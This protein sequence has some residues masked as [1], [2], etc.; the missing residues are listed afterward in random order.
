MDLVYLDGMGDPASARR[1]LHQ[2]PRR[3]HQRVPERG[4]AAGKSKLD[5]PT[6]GAIMDTILAQGKDGE[7]AATEWLKANPGPLDSW[8]AGVTTFDGKD[9]LP[10]VKAS[11]GL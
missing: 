11:L 1:R 8:L 7:T 4:Q 9:G 6:E 3:L 2:R 10:A 5:L